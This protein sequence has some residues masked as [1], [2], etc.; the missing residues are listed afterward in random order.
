LC[1]L[2]AVLDLAQAR[3]EQLDSPREAGSSTTGTLASSPRPS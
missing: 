1:D 2:G 3:F